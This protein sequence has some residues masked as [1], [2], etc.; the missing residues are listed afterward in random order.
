M[1]PSEEEVAEFCRSGER[2]EEYR[3]PEVNW[4]PAKLTNLRKV[5]MYYT[6]SGE[7]RQ[8][9]AGGKEKQCLRK[10]QRGGTIP[11]TSWTTSAGSCGTMT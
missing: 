9:P 7:I 1:V 11:L 4:V 8:G 5:C 2:G 6:T 10:R 3:D